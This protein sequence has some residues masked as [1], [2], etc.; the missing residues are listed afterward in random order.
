M[1]E[2]HLTLLATGMGEDMRPPTKE[3]IKTAFESARK[4]HS[5]DILIVYFSGHGTAVQD[6]YCYL[7][8]EARSFDLSDPSVRKQ[9]SV[10]SDELAKWIIQIPARKQAM[11]L[12][13]CEAGEAAKRLAETRQ[14]PSGQVR[15]IDRLKDRT[16]FYVL[17]GCASD[18]VSYEASQYGQG[19]L[20]YALLQG[21]QGARLRE[22]EFIDVEPLFEY[23]ADTVP[24]LAL[25]VGGI[26]RPQVIAPVARYEQKEMQRASFDIGQLKLE[27]RKMIVLP[28]PR[29]L[30]LHPR[31]LNPEEVGDSLHL[32][33]LLDVQLR[34]ES[35]AVPRGGTIV[36]VDANELPGAVE[37]KGIYSVMGGKIVV[38]VGSLWRDNRKVKE[39]ALDL[40][41][42]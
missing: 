36:Y 38:K 7:T 41:G 10:T 16:G 20:T 31:L 14:I 8:R 35:E 11:I 39:V 4:A 12:D 26:Q 37:P 34:G 17:M 2:V 27:D 30:V 13:T 23:A 24:G 15:A 5:C 3:N 6:T 1:D 21:M 29:P 28:L 25:G 42:L 32:S 9:C 33:E 22:G 40:A 18:S 19:L